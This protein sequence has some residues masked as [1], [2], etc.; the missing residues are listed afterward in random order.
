M[1][2]KKIIY[3]LIVL[4]YAGYYVGISKGFIKKDV[5]YGRGDIELTAFQRAVDVITPDSPQEKAIK[6]E[7]EIGILKQQ[8]EFAEKDYEAYDRSLSD[9]VRNP[10][11]CE[12][13]RKQVRDELAND[14]RPQKKA[15]IAKLSE[16]I[17]ALERK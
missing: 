14:K 16:K 1:S 4:V 2:I 11:T 9:A 7:E 5:R 17:A 3:T 13:G 12:L 15:Q 6:N 10:P 8:L